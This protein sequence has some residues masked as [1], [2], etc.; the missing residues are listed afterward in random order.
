MKKSYYA[1]EMTLALIQNWTPSTGQTLT[2][3][4]YANGALI[5]VQREQATIH[6][7]NLTLRKLTLELTTSTEFPEWN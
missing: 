7:P 2:Y 3:Q 6:R 4:W 5:S 1:K